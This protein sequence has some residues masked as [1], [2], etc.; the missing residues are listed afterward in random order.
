MDNNQDGPTLGQNAYRS[1][2]RKVGYY[3]KLHRGLLGNDLKGV[4]VVGRNAGGRSERMAK[5]KEI[6][7]KRER[8]YRRSPSSM[9]G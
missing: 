4:R 3:S 1:C 6:L 8:K 2:T 5:D 7:K 9:S